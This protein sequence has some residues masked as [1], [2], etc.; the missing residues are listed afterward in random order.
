MSHTTRRSI[1][2]GATALGGCLALSACGGVLGDSAGGAT[3]SAN[4]P[5]KTVTILCSSEPGS[6]VD[7][8]A[9]TL[10]DSLD[11]VGFESSVVVETVTGG[12]G[13]AALSSLVGDAPDGHTLYAMTRSQGVLLASGTLDA[14]SADD[15]DYVTGLQD[16]PYIWVTRTDSGFESM[17]DVAEYSNANPGDLTVGGFGAKSAHQL[18][19]DRI[20]TEAGVDMTWVPYEGGSE[21]VTALLGGDID[22][23]NTNPGSVLEQVRAGKLRILGAA[24]DERIDG[25]PEVP[26]FQEQGV[27]YTGS[28]WRGIVAPAGLPDDVSAKLEE[29][30]KAAFETD[31]F[32][33]LLEDQFVLPGFMPSDEFSDY[34]REDIANSE[35]LLEQAGSS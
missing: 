28:H 6:P 31:R 10:A 17:K 29:S 33:K 8:M 32:Q 24:S 7:T 25:L 9:R 27:D 3:D 4:Y 26:T 15:L 5:S 12:D 2:Q 13:A 22:I 30:L 34:V 1:L 20:S 18:A 35:D 11:D 16:D 21:A 23:A 19:A 14:V